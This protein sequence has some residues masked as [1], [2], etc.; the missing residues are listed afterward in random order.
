[1]TLYNITF[2]LSAISDYSLI[3]ALVG[4]VTVFIAL[5]LLFYV[6]RSI[7]KIINFH[8]RQRLIRE[9][10]HRGEEDLH[11]SGEESAAISMALYLYLNELHDDESHTMTIKRVS[12]QYSPWSSK[13][14]NLNPYSRISKYS[15]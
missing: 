6:F 1:M 3:V 4:Y 9:G 2:D 15:K 10:K 12:K 8:T 7:P 5:L 14:Y 13:I 11:I